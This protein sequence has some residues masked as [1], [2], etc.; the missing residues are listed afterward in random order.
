MSAL[1]D[2]RLADEDWPGTYDLVRGPNG[3]G[4]ESHLCTNPTCWCE[5]DPPEMR[6]GYTAKKA[7]FEMV[8][9][10]RHVGEHAEADRVA[11]L[12]PDELVA[13]SFP[14]ATP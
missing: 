10:L 6:C 12:T 11:A 4:L 5:N 3:W 7:H 2:A 1:T 8:S 14:E 13:E 9:M